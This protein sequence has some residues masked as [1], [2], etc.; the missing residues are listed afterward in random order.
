L[1]VGGEAVGSTTD[2][3]VQGLQVSILF[4]GDH[5]ETSVAIQRSTSSRLV[6][7]VCI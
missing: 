5:Q 4:R 3:E 6:L 2:V 7:V 1:T